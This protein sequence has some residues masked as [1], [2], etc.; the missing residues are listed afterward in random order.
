[1][2]KSSIVYRRLQRRNLVNNSF[3][4]F[5][6]PWAPGQALPADGWYD[7]NVEYMM[8]NGTY[9]DFRTK[10]A[11]RVKRGFYGK[12]GTFDERVKESEKQ[13]ASW[14]KEWEKIPQEEKLNARAAVVDCITAKP[15]FVKTD[16]GMITLMKK[17]PSGNPALERRRFINSPSYKPPKGRKPGDL[18]NENNPLL[19]N[20]S[21]AL[22]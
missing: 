14:D 22:A 12:S 13:L 17:K 18:T 9:M 10:I 7:G 11:E 4:L 16:K 2:K 20:L 1:M 6:M 3:P 21:P 5:F 8:M 15:S 19:T